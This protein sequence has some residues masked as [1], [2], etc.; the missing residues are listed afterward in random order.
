MV[1]ALDDFGRLPGYKPGSPITKSLQPFTEKQRQSGLQH[2]Q[3]NRRLRPQVG[4]IKYPSSPLPPAEQE[5]RNSQKEG[6]AFCDYVIGLVDKPTAY[7]YGGKNKREVAQEPLRYG[8]ALG[9]INEGTNQLAAV[10][11]F[12]AKQTSV[13][14]IVAPRRVI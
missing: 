9:W 12:A 13:T 4:N 10:L 2:S 8:C 6:W 7:C 5:T 14:C 11:L 1:D 3:A